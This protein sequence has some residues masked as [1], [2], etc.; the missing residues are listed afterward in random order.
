MVLPLDL[1]HYAVRVL[2]NGKTT[3]ALYRHSQSIQLVDSCVSVT[4]I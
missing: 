4:P 2:I 1:L 3:V